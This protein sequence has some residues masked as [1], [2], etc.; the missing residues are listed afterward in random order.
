MLLG[1]NQ[2]E[3]LMPGVV[4]GVFR[5]RAGGL[6]MDP[7][8]EHVVDVLRGAAAIHLGDVALRIVGVGV[9]A[10]VG[11][12]AGR[13]V[14]VTGGRDVVVGRVNR[15]IETIPSLAVASASHGCGNIGV[16]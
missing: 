11:H 13:V 7:P 3:I 16:A 10:V 8:V 1:D 2:L 5:R 14:S 15:W 12:I 9:V 4:I 6:H